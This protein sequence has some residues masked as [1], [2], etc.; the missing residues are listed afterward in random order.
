MPYVEV[1]A[2]TGSTE[3]IARFYAEIFNAV[4]HTGEDAAGRFAHVTAGPAQ[5]LIYREMSGEKARDCRHTTATMCG[6][7]WPIFRACISGCWSAV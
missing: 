7:P 3:G 4:T 2:V 6:S 5:S 1:D